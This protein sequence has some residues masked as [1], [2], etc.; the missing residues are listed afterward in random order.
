MTIGEAAEDIQDS[1]GMIRT[2]SATRVTGMKIVKVIME[3]ATGWI[4]ITAAMHMVKGT[5]IVTAALGGAGQIL[6]VA[7]IQMNGTGMTITGTG[8]I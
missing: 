6:E 8:R 2:D 1:D 3:A 4:W 7:Q 5:R